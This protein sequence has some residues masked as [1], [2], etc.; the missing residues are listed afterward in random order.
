MIPTPREASPDF[1]ISRTFDAPRERVFE[2]WTR[3]EHL[4]RWFGP[5]GFTMP[6]AN[7]D[8]RPGGSFLYCLRS[9]EGI[10]MWG[11]FTYREIVPPERLVFFSQFSDAQGGLARHPLSPDW[12]QRMLATVTF[13]DEGNGKTTVTVRSS[14]YEATGVEQKTFEAGRDSMRIGWGGTFDQ[15]AAYLGETEQA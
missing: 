3:Q 15:L 10:E 9:P 14:T 7:L 8:F 11:K 2:V 13:A 4:M 6:V 5:K 12:P 1:V